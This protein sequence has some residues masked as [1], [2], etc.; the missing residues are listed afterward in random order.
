MKFFNRLEEAE[1]Y[2]EDNNLEMIIDG[3]GSEYGVG[4]SEEIDGFAN[5][6]SQEFVDWFYGYKRLGKEG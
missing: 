5:P 2:A 3:E 1:Q 4:T 6:D